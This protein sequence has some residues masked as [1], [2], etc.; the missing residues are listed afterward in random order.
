MKIKIT[1]LFFVFNLVLVFSG[2]TAAF[3]A[4]PQLPKRIPLWLDFLSPQT[5]IQE[6]S[7]LFFIY[8]AAQT[9]FCLVYFFTTDFL[10]KKM[11]RPTVHDK[12]LAY[13]ALIF[14]N[15]VF[16]HLQT[17]LIFQAHRVE[18]GF[19][20]FYFFMLFVVILA[21]IPYYRLR[22]KILKKEGRF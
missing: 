12:E 22:I 5:L 21:L 2:W 1:S 10:L 6:K 8:A 11:R 7:P 20:P 14:F 15:L 16:I 3:L 9:L 13:L 18:K 17:S 4:Y 19:S